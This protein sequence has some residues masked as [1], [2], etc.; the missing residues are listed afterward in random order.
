MKPRLTEFSSRAKCPG[1]ALFGPM[2]FEKVKNVWTY[3]RG[4]GIAHLPILVTSRKFESEIVMG[5]RDAK[6]SGS[7]ELLVNAANMSWESQDLDPGF[8]DEMISL[9]GNARRRGGGFL[10]SQL[11]AR[12]GIAALPSCQLAVLR[13]RVPAMPWLSQGDPCLLFLL[14]SL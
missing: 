8:R 4:G 6:R 13:G 5:F 9:N 2:K 10:R 7:V 14:P 11:A 1:C 12:Q 3:Q